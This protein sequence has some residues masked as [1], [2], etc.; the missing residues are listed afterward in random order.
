MIPLSGGSGSECP[1]SVSS[2]G[3]PRKL[4]SPGEVARFFLWRRGLR[5]DLALGCRWLLGRHMLSASTAMPVNALSKW[6][7]IFSSLPPI[8]F[9]V[10]SHARSESR[11][12]W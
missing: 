2:V 11:R 10:G 8:D 3:S 9:L 5:G 1:V 4:V 12:V 7:L 6:C